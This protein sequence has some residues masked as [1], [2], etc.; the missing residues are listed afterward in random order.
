[1]LSL[2]RRHL[3]VRLRFVGQTPLRTS[4]AIKVKTDLTSVHF[5]VYSFSS[6]VVNAVHGI[7][8]TLPPILFHFL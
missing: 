4:C 6:L 7:L 1:M 8:L 2:R 5:S 3:V